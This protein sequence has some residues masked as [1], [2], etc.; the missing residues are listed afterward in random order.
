MDI[1]NK[2][3]APAP[4]V[5]LASRDFYEKGPSNY[6]VTELL[7][8]P[9][10]RKLR[11]KHQS[12]ITQDVADSLWQ[13]LGSA[14]H[15]VAERGKTENWIAEER[16][17]LEINDCLVSGQI[18]AQ[19]ITDDGIL[20]W[21]YK[22]TS[23]YSVMQDKPEWEEQLNLYAQLV[24]MVKKQ[25]IAGLRICALIRDW[26]RHKAREESYPP[27]QIHVVEIPLWDEEVAHKFL[28]ERLELHRDVHMDFEL[29]GKLPRC[30]P[31]EQWRTETTY[32]VKREGRKTAIK[33]YD[34][35]IEADQRALQEKGYVEVREGEPR[36]CTGNYCGVADWCDQHRAYLAEA[37]RERSHGEEERTHLSVVGVGMGSGSES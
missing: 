16:V 27:S 4:L 1:T 32:A 24:R 13:M 5:T 3:G 14:L 15:V 35:R 36:R 25:K 20:L 19:Q 11:Q 12:E 22:F 34:N 23:A 6:S 2:F 8:P 33:I 26:S 10:I 18:D 21:D 29:H 17:F 37:E 31:Q 9:R 30:T 7:S 28:L